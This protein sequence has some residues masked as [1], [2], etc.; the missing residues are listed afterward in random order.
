MGRTVHLPAYGTAVPGRGTVVHGFINECPMNFRFNAMFTFTPHPSR[1]PTIGPFRGRTPQ[2]LLLERLHHRERRSLQGVAALDGGARKQRDGRSV[3]HQHLRPLS[4]AK[5]AACA[6][7]PR[8]VPVVRGGVGGAVPLRPIAFKIPQDRMAAHRVL[9][10]DVAV[11]HDVHVRFGIHP[12]VGILAVPVWKQPHVRQRQLLAAPGIVPTESDA[13]ALV[14]GRLVPV[15]Q[16]RARIGQNHDRRVG[17][18]PLPGLWAT[19]RA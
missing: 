9:V 16:Q 19:C 3:A 5:R 14:V 11:V 7:A 10:V 13:D 1:T 8:D 2:G 15:Q 12:H 6:V 18:V 4:P 17:D